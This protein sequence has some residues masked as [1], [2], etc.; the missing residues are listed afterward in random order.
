MS[1]GVGSPAVAAPTATGSTGVLTVGL[2]ALAS[3]V[4]SSRARAS[5]RA[6]SASSPSST[7][8]TYAPTTRR[9]SP[10]AR[11][12]PPSSHSAS[13]QKRSTSPSECVTSRMVLPRRR[14]SLNL[15]R[16][17]WVKPSSP[18]AS[19]SSTSSTSGSTW[20]ATAN[21]RRMYIPDE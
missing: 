18:T 21:P 6:S 20:I 14:K 13:S 4:A 1:V 7:A 5:S 12:F 9:G 17:L 19:T 3:A 8:V 15:S 10:V 16:H 2:P 11:T